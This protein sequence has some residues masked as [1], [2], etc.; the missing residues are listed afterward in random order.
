MVAI[1]LNNWLT[2]LSPGVAMLAAADVWKIDVALS[3][4]DNVKVHSQL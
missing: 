2:V 1:L 3:L 4:G